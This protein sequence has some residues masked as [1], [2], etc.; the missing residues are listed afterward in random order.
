[1][2]FVYILRCADGSPYI[3]Y[4]TNLDRRIY[5]HNS[6]KVNYTINKTPVHLVTYI[7][8]KD[9]YKAFEFKRYLKTGS[10][11]AFRNRHLI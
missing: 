2:W 8:F 6:H 3:G 9:K 4:T 7:G 10:G 1:M 11:I 5:E